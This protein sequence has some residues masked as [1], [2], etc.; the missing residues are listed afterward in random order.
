MV[1]LGAQALATTSALD[2]KTAE[3]IE[4]IKF[5]LPKAFE[6][7]LAPSDPS[8]TAAGAAPSSSWFSWLFEST[9]ASATP[10][11]FQRVAADT[12]KSN[13]LDIPYEGL[14]GASGDVAT[15]AWRSMLNGD[16]AS[17]SS[18]ASVFSA[19]ALVTVLGATSGGLFP[20]A[21]GLRSVLR[22]VLG[23]RAIVRNVVQTVADLVQLAQFVA[24]MK[25]R[26]DHKGGAVMS[27]TFMTS[28]TSP[29]H[30]VVLLD[31]A[32]SEFTRG[33][34]AAGL[35]AAQLGK[36]E[37]ESMPVLDDWLKITGS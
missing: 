10:R 34:R 17:L 4:G 29:R 32:E 3:P 31:P 15:A 35:S 11:K 26:G 30:F 6:V 28:C 14:R 9:T 27:K 22:N 23:Q 20:Q 19:D 13:P 2:E 1:R 18:M 16:F 8:E 21:L 7:P 5:N 24:W 12:F 33:A 25:F 37:G 36:R